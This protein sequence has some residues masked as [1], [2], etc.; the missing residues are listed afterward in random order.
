[1]TDIESSSAKFQAMVKKF[2]YQYDRIEGKLSLLDPNAVPVTPAQKTPTKRKNASAKKSSAKK[3]KLE[4]DG[5]SGED[6]GS[7]KEVNGDEDGKSS[8]GEENGVQNEAAEG[9]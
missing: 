7:K 2:G 1:M 3:P 8:A 4:E 6:A 5:S 9:D